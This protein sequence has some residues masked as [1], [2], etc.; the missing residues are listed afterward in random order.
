LQ[1]IF[2]K[3]QKVLEIAIFSCKMA[4][5]ATKKLSN[6]GSPKSR[7]LDMRRF[8]Q[9]LFIKTCVREQGIHVMTIVNLKCKSPK[10]KK[11]CHKSIEKYS[12]IQEAALDQCKAEVA[13]YMG[14]KF[15]KTDN[16][17]EL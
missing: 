17:V 3:S 15:E 1:K 4:N 2:K 9:W 7:R 10:I 13:G 12:T 6:Y 14:G 11:L 16:I 8:I 5:Y